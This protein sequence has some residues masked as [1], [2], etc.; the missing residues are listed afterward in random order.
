[1]NCGS[2]PELRGAIVDDTDIERRADCAI[3]GIVAADRRWK[4][5]NRRPHALSAREALV[6]LEAEAFLVS[7]A[8]FSLGKGVT[9][10][11]EDRDRLLI[12]YRRIDTIA[13][14][15]TR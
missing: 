9:L 2:S 1:M 8:A 14:E 3:D 12:A 5:E 7:V 6:A 15:V 4:R 11:D 10:T 13:T